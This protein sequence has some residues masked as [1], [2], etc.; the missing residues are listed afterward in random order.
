MDIN[1]A[2]IAPLKGGCKS[3]KSVPGTIFAGLVSGTGAELLGLAQPN[4]VSACQRR[5]STMPR[6]LVDLDR[7]RCKLWFGREIERWQ[8]DRLA[9]TR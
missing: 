7:G 9:S 2:P 6:P 3:E 8:S 1:P 4:T 5:Y